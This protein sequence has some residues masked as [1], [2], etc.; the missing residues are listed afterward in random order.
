[1]LAAAYAVALMR[2]HPDLR[3]GLGVLPRVGLAVLVA[4]AVAL[5]PACPRSRR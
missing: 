5:I 2:S 4:A 3:V 1:M